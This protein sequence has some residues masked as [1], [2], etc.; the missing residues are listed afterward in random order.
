MLVTLPMTKS[1]LAILS[2]GF[3]ALISVNAGADED[4]PWTE[5]TGRLI[6]EASQGRSVLSAME[7]LAPGIAAQIRKD[8]K[9]LEYKA[10]WGK[11]VNYDELAHGTIVEEPI[12]DTIL[13]AAA[14]APRAGRVAHA[15]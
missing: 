13:A 2:L 9:E 15:G 6:L 12:L 10:F 3:I 7:E 5:I 1:S 11:S 4:S 8:S 14:A